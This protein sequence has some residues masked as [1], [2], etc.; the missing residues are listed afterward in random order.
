MSHSY[1]SDISRE[2]FAR[3]LPALL[4][5]RRRTKPRTVDWYDVFCDVFCGVLYVLKSG[6][7]WRMLP[8]DLPQWQ[9]CCKYFR[10]WSERPN[11]RQPSILEQVLKKSVAA[12]RQSNGRKERTTF[13]IVDAVSWMPRA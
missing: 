8:A 2:Q 7:Q 3:V 9:T 1:P 11:P 5:A 12:V 6:C 4:T 13:R 10:Q